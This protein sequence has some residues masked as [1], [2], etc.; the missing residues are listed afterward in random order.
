LIATGLLTKFS[1]AGLVPGAFAALVFLAIR[2]ARHA[3]QRAFRAPA[4]A[5]GIACIPAMVYVVRNVLT[6]QPTFGII[7]GSLNGIHGT[8]PAVVNYDWQLYLPRL[9]GTVSDFPGLSSTRQIWFDGYVGRLGW[10]DTFFPEWVYTAALFVAAPIAALIIRALLASRAAVRA[11]LGEL[12]AYALMSAGLLVLVG[13]ASYLVFP[14]QTASYGQ[15]RYLL[16]LL[17]LFSVLLALS[18]RG[19]GRRWGPTVGT[20]IVVLFLAHDVFSQLQTISR[21]YG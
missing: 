3:Q 12:A 9:P 4:V 17:P 19:A 16:Q 8:L 21:Y 20:L 10:L 13:T 15:T 18:A 14:F 5:A 6:H 2:S 1:F 11:R 7:I